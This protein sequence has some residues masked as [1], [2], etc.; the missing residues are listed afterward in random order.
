M[1]TGHVVKLPTPVL[2]QELAGFFAQYGD[3]KEVYCRVEGG[4]AVLYLVTR[5]DHGRGTL[6]ASRA[7][8]MLPEEA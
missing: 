8:P 3:G 2:A 6:F 4:K 7:V 5:G 1:K